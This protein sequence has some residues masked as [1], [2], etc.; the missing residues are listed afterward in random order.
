MGPAAR[1]MNFANVTILPCKSGDDLDEIK[2]VLTTNFKPLKNT[3]NEKLVMSGM[4]RK[5]GESMDDFAT[6]LRRQATLCDLEGDDETREAARAQAK[7][8]AE[9][10]RSG[11][12]GA[13]EVAAVRNGDPR[14]GALRE[15]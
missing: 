8:I 2:T 14:R 9:S 13:S 11:A 5:D 1:E 3:D 12:M 7:D 10:C 6:R 4:K 15:R